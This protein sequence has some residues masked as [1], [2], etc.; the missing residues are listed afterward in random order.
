MEL[1][2]K[3]NEVVTQHLVS[4]RQKEVFADQVLNA[5]SRMNKSGYFG[6]GFS[7]SAYGVSEKQKVVPEQVLETEITRMINGGANGFRRLSYSF[8]L[9]LKVKLDYVS[10]C[11]KAILVDELPNSDFPVYDLDIPEFGAVKIASLGSPVFYETAIQRI[12]CPTWVLN[13]LEPIKYE[14]V[15]IRRY[16]AFNRAKERVGIALSIGEDD[17]FFK[18]L[19]AASVVSPNTPLTATVA[20]KGVLTTA[21]GNITQR[22]LVASTVIMNPK[23]YAQL[24]NM[25]S[26]DLDQVT[27]NTVIET[28]YFG[29]IFGLL[30]I[31]S[32]RCPVNK[33][34]VVTTK[35]KLGRLPERKKVEV[36]VF[37]YP[38]DG[39][40]DIYGWEQIG[41]LIHNPG[42]V[43]RIDLTS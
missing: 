22:Q 1:F 24:L 8:Q 39:E 35:D 26:S 29:S 36:K 42:G 27:L 16:P 40:Y 15:N 9:P 12:S 6:D 19:Q 33:M 10:V 28:G 34:Y 23:Q 17:E 32:T 3:N 11:R 18:L 41:Q 31:V 38:R 37:D 30:L 5:L 2:N 25:S 43:Q 13:I 7:R 4:A 14:D 20:S 21:I